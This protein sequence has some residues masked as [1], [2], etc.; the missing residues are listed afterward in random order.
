RALGAAGSV[1]IGKIPNGDRG[2]CGRRQPGG[3]RSG[4]TVVRRPG[5]GSLVGGLQ[6]RRPEAP[7]LAS[8]HVTHRPRPSGTQPRLLPSGLYRRLRLRR[9]AVPVHRSDL[10]TPAVDGEPLVGSTPLIGALPPVG[11]H[12]LPRRQRE[13]STG[14]RPISRSAGLARRRREGR[15]AM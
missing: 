5:G 2:R 7:S 11:N 8:G 10:L 9:P 1:G 6:R 14:D 12:T 15:W 4:G 13:S 3:R